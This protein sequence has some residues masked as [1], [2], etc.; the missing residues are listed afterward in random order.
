[1]DRIV[2]GLRGGVV[3]P[4]FLLQPQNQQPQ[5]LC[6]RLSLLG[7]RKSWIPI[8]ESHHR[9]NASESWFL[10]LCWIQTQTPYSTLLRTSAAEEE[11]KETLLKAE[12]T[13]A[14]G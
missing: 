8:R 11:G 5:Q 10:P 6:L 4:P 3:V 14:L 13:T 12:V 9:Q 7:L 1:M 2:L